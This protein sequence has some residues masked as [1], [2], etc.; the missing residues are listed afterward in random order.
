MFPGTMR[1]R[2]LNKGFMIPESYR[3]PGILFVLRGR[4]Q[5]KVGN[6]KAVLGVSDYFTINSYEHLLPPIS[7]STIPT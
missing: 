2:F 1:F 4:A 3:D 5:V 6:E 7:L